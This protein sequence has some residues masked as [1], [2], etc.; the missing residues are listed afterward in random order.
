MIS[1]EQFKTNLFSL[2]EKNLHEFEPDIFPDWFR[3]GA[4]LI[5]FWEQEEQIK[6]VLTKRSANVTH[7]PGQISLP[8]GSLMENETC[9]QAALRESEEE[10]GLDTNNVQIAGGLNPFWSFHRFFL[11]PVLGWFAGIPDFSENENEV[12][13]IIISDL[14]DITHSGNIRTDVISIFNIAFERSVIN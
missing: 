9:F 14:L 1:N 2:S 5:L 4:V 13:K 11:I 3:K 7:D 8:G 12:E 10:I 6:V